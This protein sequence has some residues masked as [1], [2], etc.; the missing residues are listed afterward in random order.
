MTPRSRRQR[1]NSLQQIAA[2]LRQTA[3]VPAPDLS[4]SILDKVDAR[5]PF[6]DDKTRRMLWAGRAALGLSVA[7]VV[8]GVALTHRWAP[9]AVEL[10][11]RPAPFSNVVENVRSEAGV[12]L[13]E[14]RVAAGAADTGANKSNGGLLSLITTAAPVQTARTSTCSFCGPVLSPSD[15][16]RICTS[17]LTPSADATGSLAD[18]KISNSTNMLG[19]SRIFTRIRMVSSTVGAGIDDGRRL[20]LDELAP[21]GSGAA[22][23]S[24]LSP[25]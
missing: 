12:R 20:I 25:K 14:L 1:L 11:S 8:L 16:A 18:R 22:G 7:V 15:A 17:S 24:A 13:V 6:L 2:Q 10:V 3:D 5:R 9:N 19:S 23:D 4:D 21:L